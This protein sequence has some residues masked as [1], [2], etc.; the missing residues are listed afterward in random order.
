[1]THNPPKNDD[2]NEISSGATYKVIMSMG[3]AE[4]RIMKPN[5]GRHDPTNMG[6]I[7]HTKNSCIRDTHCRLRRSANRQ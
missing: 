3:Q 4:K 7:T 6:V 5:V 2:M 1:M